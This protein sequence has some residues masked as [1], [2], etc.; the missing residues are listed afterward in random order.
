M[1]LRIPDTE[2]AGDYIVVSDQQSAQFFRSLVHK[3]GCQFEG[4]R[5]RWWL[6]SNLRL[7]L[8]M[9][10]EWRLYVVPERTSSVEYGGVIRD[11][12]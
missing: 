2:H 12:T 3:G 8:V 1:S 6:D 9:G 5:M 4:G 11:F 7:E 10:I